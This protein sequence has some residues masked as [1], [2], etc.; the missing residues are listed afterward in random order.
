MIS[1]RPLVGPQ[2]LYC[3]DTVEKISNDQSVIVNWPQPVFSN[4]P[5]WINS[6]IL[7]GSR[8]PVP[9]VNMVIYTASDEYGHTAECRFIVKLKSKHRKNQLK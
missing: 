4:N 6:N 7:R 2:V 1:D 8:F 9:S 3:P 5:R